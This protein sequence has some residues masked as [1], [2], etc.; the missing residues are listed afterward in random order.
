[1]V[2]RHI[3]GFVGWFQKYDQKFHWC[4]TILY[5]VSDKS[6]IAFGRKMLRLINASPYCLQ[7]VEWFDSH[8]FI[9]GSLKCC[10][11]IIFPTEP[12][13]IVLS[14]SIIQT[15]NTTATEKRTKNTLILFNGSQFGRLFF[16]YILV[17]TYPFY[18]E[19]PKQARARTQNNTSFQSFSAHFQYT[20]FSRIQ[21]N[22][23]WWWCNEAFL[24]WNCKTVPMAARLQKKRASNKT[25]TN[26]SQNTYVQ[27]R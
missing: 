22:C 18:D 13:P 2:L 26:S 10:I 25:R 3:M 4:I 24:I 9:N 17:F 15:G 19:L 27:L 12:R 8:N 5:S 21:I 14:N 1:M 6:A 7:Y 16:F 20:S 11:L 23:E